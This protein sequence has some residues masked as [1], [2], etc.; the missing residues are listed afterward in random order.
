MYIYL[1]DSNL[2]I[3]IVVH[4]NIQCNY[5]SIII[6]LNQLKCFSFL[7]RNDLLICVRS[8]TVKGNHNTK[9]TAAYIKQA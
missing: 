7:I 1:Y 6:I 4:E 8:Q 3:Y 2:E 5:G 9:H